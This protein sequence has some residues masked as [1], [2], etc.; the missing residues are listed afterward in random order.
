MGILK[1]GSHTSPSPLLLVHILIFIQ[2]APLIVKA[3]T[4]IPSKY[5]G[6]VYKNRPVTTD[7]IIIE[8]FLDPVCID[9][10]D[11]WP[12][13]KQAIHHYPSG[14]ISL[15][16]HTFPLPY[17]DNA[18][19]TSRALH[20]VNSINSSA[21]YDL[22]DLFFDD[23][24]RFYNS[25]TLNDSRASV[26]NQVIQVAAKAVGKSNLPAIQSGFRDSE[27]NYA[28]RNSFEYG[29]SR[30]VSGAPFFFVNGFVLPDGGLA[31]TYKKWRSIIDPLVGKAKRKGNSFKRLSLKHR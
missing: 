12:P 26:V 25:Q 17:H 10:K 6:F 2:I 20:I 29:C 5:D 1:Q 4:L 21:T 24:E 7:S 15:I 18:F 3:Q 31:I 19:V 23:Q 27:T 30:G 11:S 22:L 16:V 14:S 8:A 9:S 13:L 28:T